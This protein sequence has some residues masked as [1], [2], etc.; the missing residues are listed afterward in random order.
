MVNKEIA[1]FVR[2]RRAAAEAK[3]DQSQQHRENIR[4]IAD[5]LKFD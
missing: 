5:D 4:R 3:V 1:E 2:K